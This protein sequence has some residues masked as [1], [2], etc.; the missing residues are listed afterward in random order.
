MSSVSHSIIGSSSA[1]M[2]ALHASERTLKQQEVFGKSS[3]ILL[4]K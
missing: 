3:A 2:R 4:G 1:I